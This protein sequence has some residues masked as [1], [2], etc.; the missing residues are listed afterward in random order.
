MSLDVVTSRETAKIRIRD[1]RYH[2]SLG[3]VPAFTWKAALCSGKSSPGE[4]MLSN[5]PASGTILFCDLG[6]VA[7]PL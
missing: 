1:Y 7:F 2:D 5:S 3:D 4:E 6:P